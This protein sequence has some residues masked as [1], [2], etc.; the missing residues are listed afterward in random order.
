M[1]PGLSRTSI[2]HLMDVAL[3]SAGTKRI[4]IVHTLVS[5]FSKGADFTR[6]SVKVTGATSLSF[7]RFL[8]EER[9]F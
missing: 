3:A 2:L 1:L 9:F 6:R 4:V 7:L 8:L 5:Y